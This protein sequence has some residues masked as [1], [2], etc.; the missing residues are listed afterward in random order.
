MKSQT[1]TFT[2]YCRIGG[3]NCYPEYMQN[4]KSSIINNGILKWA[5]KKLKLPTKRYM[6]D[7]HKHMK[8][9]LSSGKYKLKLRDTTYYTGYLKKT[10]Q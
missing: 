4:F 8:R 2:K 1:K 6:D 5:K 10:K 3:K 7:L 9:G